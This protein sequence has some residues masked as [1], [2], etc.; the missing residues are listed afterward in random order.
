MTG[1]DVVLKKLIEEANAGQVKSKEDYQK[2]GILYCGKCNT[3]KQMWLQ[4]DFLDEVMK[5]PVMCKCREKELAEEKAKAEEEER[6]KKRLRSLGDGRFLDATFENSEQTESN[7]KAFRIFKNYAERYPEMMEKN[8]GLLIYGDVG[9]GKTWLSACIA[10]KLI[11][12]GISVKM[13]TF[14]ELLGMD[15]KESDEY[16]ENLNKYKLL[17]IDDFGA[18]R[19]TSFA[20]EK[21][22][23]VIDNRYKLKKPFVITTNLNL[24]DMKSESRMVYRRIYDRVLEV[25]Y[26]IKLTGVSWRMKDAKS[27]YIE[28]SKLFK[29]LEDGED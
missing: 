11:D 4:D 22:Y 16:I 10:N 21:V 3:P 26:P 24:E 15:F 20:L 14:A 13:M 12:K 28:M 23:Q 6:K 2:D 19:D 9:T 1:V 17:I 5:V 29:E 8:Q 27:R 25:C 18:E 7:K